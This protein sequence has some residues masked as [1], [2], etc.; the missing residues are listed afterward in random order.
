[1]M[2]DIK[3][4]RLLYAKGVLFLVLGLMASAMLVLEAPQVK[5]VLLLAVAVWAFCRFYYFM[6][7]VIEHYVDPGYRFSGMLGFARYVAVRRGRS[8][9]NG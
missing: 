4:I 6:F 5:I 8:S 1:M 3:N 9:G 7:Y 2:G